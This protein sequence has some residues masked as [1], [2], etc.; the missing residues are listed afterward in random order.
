MDSTAAVREMGEHKEDVP[1][2]ALRLDAAYQE[3]DHTCAWQI[4]QRKLEMM[5]AQALA[6]EQ[7]EQL[8]QGLSLDASSTK[9]LLNTCGSFQGAS[10]KLTS[11]SFLQKLERAL[12]TEVGGSE[13]NHQRRN[14]AAWCRLGSSDSGR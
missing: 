2:S 14:A 4:A 5:Q 1:W 13:D 3:L 8:A 6:I 7:E 11:G 12:Q 9:H 10:H